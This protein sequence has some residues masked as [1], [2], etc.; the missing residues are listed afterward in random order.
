LTNGHPVIESFPS[1]FDDERETGVP[2][3]FLRF[4]HAFGGQIR[5][6]DRAPEHRPLE[7]A[8][9][10]ERKHHDEGRPEHHTK[11]DAFHAI[12]LTRLTQ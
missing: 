11:G 9:A 7:R 3:D 6:E 12:N 4:F 8:P 10:D 2:G 5:D 1:F